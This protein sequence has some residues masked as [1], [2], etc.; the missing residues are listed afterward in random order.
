MVREVIAR[1]K[2]SFVFFYLL[3]IFSV[4]F[5]LIII[6]N[7]N[8]KKNGIK[9]FIVKAQYNYD[10]YSQFLK[11]LKNLQENYYYSEDILNLELK[12]LRKMAWDKKKKEDII[13]LIFLSRYKLKE[14]GKDSNLYYTLGECFFLLGE[15]EYKNSLNYYNLF[16][17]ESKKIS[18]EI[19]LK[20][21]FLNL[22]LENYKIAEQFAI[23][24][25]KEHSDNIDLNL[26]YIKSLIGQ[27]K[28]IKAYK[29][30]EQWINSTSLQNNQKTLEI[31]NL[32]FFLL[33]KFNLNHKID[34]YYQKLI[35]L[36]DYEFQFVKK[37][38]YFLANNN[39]K[40]KAINLVHSAYKKKKKKK[41]FLLL[42][43]IYRI[44][45]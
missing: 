13:K 35:Q 30:I 25:L 34:H 7:Y 12:L 43:Q 20:T 29:K 17:K 44:K 19:S 23:G 11:K 36:T 24:K 1:R 27:K 2:I 38:C 3:F 5:L 26:Y 41:Y 14:Y 39:E 10:F 33:E 45:T 40:R 15:K 8:I 42:K 37:Y 6:W 22:F 18:L 31:F 32:L 28:N 9:K 21:I 16:L 4:L